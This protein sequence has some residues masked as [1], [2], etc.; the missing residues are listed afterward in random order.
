[1]QAIHAKGVETVIEAGPGKVLTGLNKRIEKNLKGLAV[2]DSE[3]LNAA[4]EALK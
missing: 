2:F 1:M 4:L 3:G